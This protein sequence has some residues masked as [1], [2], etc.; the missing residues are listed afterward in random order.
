MLPP[1]F[2]LIESG[3][4]ARITWDAPQPLPGVITRYDLITSAGPDDAAV[5]LYSGLDREVVIDTPASLLFRVRASTIS[6]TGPY[7]PPSSQL[8][9]PKGSASSSVE[10]FVPIVGVLLVL[11][12]IAVVVAVVLRRQKQ[13]IKRKFIVPPPDEWERSRSVVSLGNKLGEGNFGIVYSATVM[14]ITPDLPGVVAA[15]VKVV[16]DTAT[17]EE[18]HSFLNEAA[19][20]KLISKPWHDN[21]RMLLLLLLMLCSDIVDSFALTVSI[22]HILMHAGDSAAWCVHAAGPAHDHSRVRCTW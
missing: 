7:S 17:P 19:L 10:T 3:M 16:V 8:Q 15:A 13:A 1:V 21:V 12:I 22:I 14:N 9:R 5:M 2:E 18:K 4:I 6:G 20:M 11:F